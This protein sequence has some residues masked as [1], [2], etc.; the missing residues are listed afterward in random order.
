MSLFWWPSIQKINGLS[1]PYTNA[2]STSPKL[3]L[4]R[5]EGR[6]WIL[7]PIRLH[8]ISLKQFRLSSFFRCPWTTKWVRMAFRILETS[9][10]R[11]Q[12]SRFLRRPEAKF[13]VLRP[14]RI[15]KPSLKRLRPI[16]LFFDTRDAKNECTWPFD[17]FKN[18]FIDFT[19]V[20]F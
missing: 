2:S 7:R 5:P 11:I 8:E 14:I 3:F 10:H 13:W 9:L 17:T 18:H 12:Q 6:L 15:L 19:K 20:V 1:T 16:L 4:W